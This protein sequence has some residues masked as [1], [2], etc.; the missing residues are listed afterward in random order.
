[1]KKR[2]TTEEFDRFVTLPENADRLFEYCAGEVVEV[3]S[4]NYSSE[5]AML[6]GAMLVLFVKKERLGHVTGA[7]GGY[8]VA[9][10]RFIP[11]VAF[12]S[13]SRQPHPSREA[14]NPSPPDLAVEVL[15]PSDDSA[16]LRMKVVSY[17]KAGT[18]VWVVDPD[19]KQVEIYA[20]DQLPKTAN[21]DDTLAGGD[22]LPG[23]TLPVKDIFPEEQE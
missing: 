1:V 11:D 13:S 16:N 12:I 6:I 7:D 22:V 10:Q 18:V 5:I 23:F 2:Y 14:Y 9:G 19:K 17:L 15:S 3:V 4:N 20:P 21:L 8:V